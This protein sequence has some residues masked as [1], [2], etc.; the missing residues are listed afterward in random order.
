MLLAILAFSIRLHPGLVEPGCLTE[1]RAMRESLSRV[2][3]LIA[4]IT[5]GAA[6][7]FSGGTALHAEDV[8][9][10]QK[11]NGPYM[12]LARVF[13]GVDA[14]KLAKALASELRQEHKLSAYIYQRFRKGKDPFDE[15]AVLVG[16]AQTLKES[17]SILKQV[18]AISPRCLADV[19]K[20]HRRDLARAYRTTNPLNPPANRPIKLR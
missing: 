13:R 18:R 3:L 7:L 1:N 19:S 14:E 6:V 10:L 17:E 11:E 5:V 12:V 8:P 15:V 4:P 16:D 9:S 20:L 2:C